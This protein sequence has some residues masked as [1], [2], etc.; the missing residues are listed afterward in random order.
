ML[1]VGCLIKKEK[2]DMVFSVMK[3]EAQ[4]IIEGQSR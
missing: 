2:T 3:F 1:V 4:D